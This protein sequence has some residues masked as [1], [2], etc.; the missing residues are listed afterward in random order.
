MNRLRIAAG[1]LAMAVVAGCQ[2]DI[3]GPLQTGNWGGTGVTMVVSSTGTAFEFDCAHG[4]VDARLVASGG[5]F[6]MDGQYVREHGGPVPEESEEDP[7]PATYD[8][9]IR[10][11][12][13]TLFVKLEDLQAPI[14]PYVLERGL[15]G[16]LR[17]CL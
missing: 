12:T 6:S 7:V 10:G 1:L 2:E 5:R 17:K 16:G 8:G 3:N 13:M 11:S 4:F 9:T 15:Q 14:G